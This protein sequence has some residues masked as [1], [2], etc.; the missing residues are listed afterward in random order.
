MVYLFHGNVF[1][2]NYYSGDYLPSSPTTTTRPHPNDHY[3]AHAYPYTHLFNVLRT[4]ATWIGPI[5]AWYDVVVNCTPKR[6]SLPSLGLHSPLYHVWSVLSSLPY[7]GTTS[8]H[9]DI[10]LLPIQCGRSAGQRG[11]IRPS[12]RRSTVPASLRAILHLRPIA[13]PPRPMAQPTIRPYSNHSSQA[14]YQC[15]NVAVPM[16]QTKGTGRNNQLSIN[17]ET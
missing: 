4:F 8:G 16:H 1:H 14:M 7:N 17:T 9:L 11:A 10:R 12:G 2:G 3:H 6:T 13:L 5:T 15:A